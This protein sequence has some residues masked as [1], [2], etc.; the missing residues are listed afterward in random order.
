MSDDKLTNDGSHVES[1]QLTNTVALVGSGEARLSSRYDCNVYAIDAPD[2][3]V[4]IDTGAGESVPSLIEEV[5]KTFGGVSHA[6]LTHA[7]ADH[8]QGG[9]ECMEA[10]IEVIA[11]EPTAQL[12]SN[13]S[14]YDL[15][16]DAARDEGVYPT[17]YTFENY[18][19]NQTFAPGETITVAGR[20]FK[21]IQ[22]R[23]HAADHVAY[24]ASETDQTNCFVGDAVYPDGRISLL[25]IPGSSLTHY[26]SDINSL[27]DQ[28]IDAL[29]P[30]HGLPMLADGQEA[31]EQAAEELLGMSVPP[32]RT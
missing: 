1:M 10:D 21:T 24:L 23:G 19:V 16:I 29:F 30:G 25:N 9:P 11:S 13:G 20:R 7:H 15:G 8:S 17:E 5:E 18:T 22:L 31:V 4:L 27:T 2:G 3:T 32:S 12:L 26:R 6:L 28:D 14:E